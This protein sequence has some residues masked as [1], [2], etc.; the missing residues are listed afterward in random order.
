MKRI[1]IVG[2]TSAIAT[3]CARRWAGEGSAFFLVAR[4]AQKLEQTATDL[5]TRGAEK[6]AV[7]HMDAMDSAAHTPML[8]ACLSTLGAID[9]ALISYG[10]L[11][12]QKACEQSAALA[13]EAFAL[14]A[15]SVIALATLIANRLEAQRA[16][17]LAV[18]SSVAGDR[19]RASNYVYGAAKAAVS[20][21]CAGL[22]ARLAKAGAHVVLIKPGF[23]DTP[24]TK[25][26]PLPAALLATPD[27]VAAD[28]VRA[29]ARNRATLYTPWVWS[30]IMLIVRNIPEP[31]FKRLNL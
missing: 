29:I 11:P 27:Q 17:T 26:L 21:F 4:D 6:V 23:V 13:A 3:A 31:L 5:R 16:G 18:I 12:D 19:G 15:T 1:L 22:R 24:M 28:I 14:N 8:D 2:A 10:T 9:I 30:P 7:H 25:G 20:T